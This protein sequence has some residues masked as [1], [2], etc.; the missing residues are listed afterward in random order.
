VLHLRIVAPVDRA[1]KALELLG[2]TPSVCNLIKL[3]GAAMQ[4]EGDVILCDIAREDA[5]VILADLRELQIDREGSIAIEAVDTEI[6]TAADEAERAAVGAASDAVVWE[7]VEARTSESAELSGSFVGFM[8]LACVIAAVGIYLDTPILIIG[9]MVVGPEFGPVAGFCVALVQR[10]R[11]LALRSFLA[12]AV[13]FPLGITAAW[14]LTLVFEATNVI[15]RRFDSASHSLSALIA[16]PT[17]LTVFVAFA[18]GIVGVLSLTSAKSGALVGV[19]ISVTTIPA[20][21]NI[22]VAAAYGDGSSWRGSMAQLAA[23]LAAI[24]T[25]GTLTLLAQRLLYRRRRAA[26]LRD[27]AR[28]LAGLGE[29]GAARIGITPRTRARTTPPASSGPAPRRR[30]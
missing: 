5:S 1:E 20:A 23:N 17:F 26:H 3:P 15:P 25:A 21:A 8:V 29:G 2:A 30:R 4:P 19:L 16:D 7:E 10:R 6:S 13:G 22:G 11:R 12:L 14:A 27:P 18:A 24:L 9:A 28:A